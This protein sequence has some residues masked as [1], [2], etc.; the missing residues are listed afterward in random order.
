[1]EE[2]SLSEPRLFPE[3][4]FKYDNYRNWP[5]NERWEILKGVAVDITDP[6][7][8]AHQEILGNLCFSFKKLISPSDQSMMMG[9]FD[10]LLASEGTP[11]K[12][13]DTIVQPDFMITRRTNKFTDLFYLGVP[14]F[15]AEVICP[16]R[17]FLDLGTKL[18]LYEEFGVNEYWILHPTECW[19]L[20]HILTKEGVYSRSQCFGRSDR[21]IPQTFPD[22]KI[23]LSNVFPE[24]KSRL[25]R[26]KT[27]I[28]ED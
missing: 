27:E 5:N 24:P 20:R 11:E 19:L 28:F 7:G 18:D 21:I 2:Q 22:L 12:E 1:M 9:P 15:I 10:L 3:K 13:V 8:V 4:H 16:F 25:R 17:A 6:P 14:D 26:L 23:D